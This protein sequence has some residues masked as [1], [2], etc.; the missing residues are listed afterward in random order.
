MEQEKDIDVTN[1]QV[2]I[3]PHKTPENIVQS[4]ALVDASYSLTL[5][6]MRLI[7]LA[8]N[9]IHT[10]VILENGLVPSIDITPQEFRDAFHINSNTV[11]ERLSGITDS[12]FDKDIVTYNI[13][14]KGK[15]VTNRQRWFTFVKYVVDDSSANISLRFAPELIPYLY[16]IS[17]NFTK[18]D[19]KELA[20]L[21]TPFAMRLYQY[22]SQFRRMRKY[23][24]EGGAI[25]TPAISFEDLKSRFG[26]TGKY[27]KFPIFRRDVLEPAIQKI[28]HFTDLSATFATVTKGRKVTGVIFTVLDQKDGIR[29][30]PARKRLPGRPSAKSGSNKEWEWMHNCITILE[31]HRKELKAYD[32]ALELPKVDLVRL[33][34]YYNG[35]MEHS[36]AQRIK[37]IIDK[38]KTVGPKKARS[39]TK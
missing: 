39:K 7:Y 37:E 11:W 21:D 17:D 18:L 23:K 35:I 14:G 1:S 16:D 24:R 20:K 30:K 38:G 36:Q 12:L 25:E 32:P 28:T 15:Q 29:V 27:E 19:F 31:E 5:D 3:I 34:G 8:M 6:E 9:K 4:N 13:D 22:L 10:P 2:L 26:L 33:A